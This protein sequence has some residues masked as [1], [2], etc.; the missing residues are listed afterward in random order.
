MQS[1]LSRL[2]MVSVSRDAKTE[3]ERTGE[4]FAKKPAG[5]QATKP[6]ADQIAIFI[7]PQALTFPIVVGV[8]KVAWEGFMRLPVSWAGSLWVPFAAC[9]FIGFVITIESVRIEKLSIPMSTLGVFI[10]ILNSFV[11]FAAVLGITK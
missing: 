4:V 8:V 3:D 1:L 11:M 5:A 7:R 9:L 6:S 2:T 10:G